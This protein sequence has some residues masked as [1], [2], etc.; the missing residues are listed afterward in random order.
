[1]PDAQAPAASVSSSVNDVARWLSMMLG[2]GA[3]RGKRI[4]DAAALAPAV[5]QQV[6]TSPASAQRA[7]GYYGYGFNVGTTAAGLGSF[8]HSGAFA[9]G[10]GTTFLVVPS[11]GLGIVVLTNGYPIGIPETLAAQ[12]F[13]LVQFGSV[14]Q[15]WGEIYARLFQPLLAPEGSL[16]G[17]APPAHPLPAQKLSAYVGAFSN[18]YYGPLRVVAQPD[19]LLTLVLGATPL[20]LPLTHWDGDVFTFKLYNE[21]AAPGTISKA[22]FASD[23]VTL[24][25]Y[26]QE[27]LG[28]F[29]RVG[30]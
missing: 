21:N 26:D 17:V 12:F 1:M 7:A 16:F 2:Q 20:Q 6:L 23:R 5:A 4:V 15:P 30:A 19:G 27:K 22:T 11:T 10:A 29:L 13:D 8:G 28:T 14:Q 25:Y 3:Y 9:L 24:E 18:H